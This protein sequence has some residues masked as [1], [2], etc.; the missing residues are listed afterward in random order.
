M[1]LFRYEAIDKDG[2][3]IRGVMDGA[4][5]QTVAERLRAMGFV[6]QRVFPAPG[7]EPAKPTARGPARHRLPVSVPSSVPLRVLAAFLRR[8]ATSV[9]SG[10]SVSQAAGDLA[11]STRHHA[12]RRAAQD[13]S[14]VLANRSRLG[15]AMYAH[16]KIFPAHIAG[17][18]AAGE[19]GG[20]LDS[21]LDDAASFVE[22]ESRERLLGWLIRSLWWMTIT[23]LPFIV[24]LFF[25]DRVV[26]E[27]FANPPGEP[28]GVF[29][30]M[31]GGYWRDFLRYG[32]PVGVAIF[33]V[34]V[35][36][37]WLLRPNPAFRR[38]MDRLVLAVPYLGRQATGQATAF[39]TSSLGRLYR[40]GVP[41]DSAWELACRTVP[42]SVIGE[43]LYAV[44][45][46]LLRGQTVQSALQASGLFSAEALGLAASAETSGSL[47]EALE[48]IAAFSSD[49][50]NVA[51]RSSQFWNT[52]LGCS[53]LLLINGLILI[54]AVRAW[55]APVVK[56]LGDLSSGP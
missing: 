15:E 9:R 55:L 30:A 20:F 11:S 12:M 6:A 14:E 52:S 10:I 37:A 44:R 39:F 36:Q 46:A 42:N 4:D 26:N 48:R 49:E 27:V 32:L 1:P 47:P 31:M 25:F 56:M 18:I 53:A 38:M 40:A 8:L 3:P 54:F 16:P 19:A 29:A 41:P 22:H 21:A 35:L 43:R 28:Y 7:Q 13:I 5:M 33:V 50:A 34:R 2:K 17:L 51:L 45:D 24:P 23:A